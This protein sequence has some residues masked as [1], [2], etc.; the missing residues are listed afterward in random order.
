MQVALHADAGNRHPGIEQ[1]ADVLHVV[2]EPVAGGDVVI[3]DEQLRVRIAL[4]YPERHLPNEVDPEPLLVV[5]GVHHFV[6]EVVLGESVAIAG[7]DGAPPLG[8]RGFEILVVHLLQPGLDMVRHT[9]ENAVAAQ[10]NALLGGPGEHV[11]DDAVIHL[12]FLPF[13]D[14]PL[15]VGLGTPALK[16]LVKISFHLAMSSGVLRP[17]KTPPGSVAP[18]QNSWRTCS[19]VTLAPGAVRIA[20]VPMRFLAMAES[21]PASAAYMP[22][23]PR[24]SS[25]KTDFRIPIAVNLARFAASQVV[26]LCGAVMR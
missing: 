21:R 13:H 9:P 19:T 17:E 15:E 7:A 4:L 14:V 6:V 1:F 22:A 16:W 3:I 8:D 11:V 20:S 2:V 26:D 12:V 10:R 18:N 24:S 5:V 25:E 23:A